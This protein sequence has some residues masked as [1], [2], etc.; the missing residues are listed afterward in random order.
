MVDRLAADGVLLLH[1]A[2]IGFVVLGAV[3]ALRWPWLLFAQ[4]PAA[5]WG[6]FVELTGRICPLTVVENRLR[7]RAGTSG[8]GESFVEHYLLGVIYPG[9]LTREG[10][11]ALA[12]VVLIVNGAIYAWILHRLRARSPRSG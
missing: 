9:G 6:T 10:Q 12:A 8:Y 1:L 2:F 7:R 4:I 11:V 3:A 5:A